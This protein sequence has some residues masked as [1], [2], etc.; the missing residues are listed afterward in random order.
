MKVLLYDE[1]QTQTNE[2]QSPTVVVSA[3]GAVDANPTRGI[4]A[5]GGC[6]TQ[7]DSSSVASA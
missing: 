3:Y 6:Q 1:A 5:H 7:S 2:S 4:V